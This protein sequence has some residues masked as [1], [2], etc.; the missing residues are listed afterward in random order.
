[1]DRRLK[2]GFDGVVHV[3]RMTLNYFSDLTLLLDQNDVAAQCLGISQLF[4]QMQDISVSRLGSK[5]TTNR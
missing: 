4:H 5:A 3:G 1:M 2:R